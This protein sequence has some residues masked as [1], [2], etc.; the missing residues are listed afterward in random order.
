M[1]IDPRLR[2]S[3]GFAHAEK[4]GQEQGLE[5]DK[6]VLTVVVGVSLAELITPS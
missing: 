1:G 4:L 5:Q 3:L 2:V 6:M